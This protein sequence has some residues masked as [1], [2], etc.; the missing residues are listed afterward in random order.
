M[1][2]RCRHAKGGSER[3]MVKGRSRGAGEQQFLLSRYSCLSLSLLVNSTPTLLLLLPTLLLRR[4][5]AFVDCR[6]IPLLLLMCCSS[7]ALALS[8]S[9]VDLL[10]R[11]S[12]CSLP[13]VRETAKQHT[14]VQ[15]VL[16]C[17]DFQKTTGAST[18]SISSAEAKKQQQ[19]QR[20]PSASLSLVKSS[21][22]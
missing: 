8:L 10:S 15:P 12:Q 18:L 19:Q 21:L 17:S 2:Q 13:R 3:D 1:K 5:P 16:S 9:P 7:R 20:H 22:M 14:A 6:S 4:L 11:A